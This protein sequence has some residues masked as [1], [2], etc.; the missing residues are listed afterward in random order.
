MLPVIALVGRPNVG[1]STFFNLLTKSRDALVADLPG[2]T[3]DRLYG[4]GEFEGKK[5]IVIDTG[6]LTGNEAGIDGLMAQQTLTAIEEADSIF[7]I[8]DGRSGLTNNDEVLA[9]QLRQFHKPIHLVVNKTDGVNPDI[10]T[11]EFNSLGLGLPYGISATH[12]QGVR[13]LLTNLIAI[14]ELPAENLDETSTSIKTA[15]IG[16]PNAGKSTLINRMLGEERQL[17]FDAPGTTRDSVYIPFTRHEKHYTLIDTA[18]VRRR[19]KIS[20]TVEKFSV[21]KTLQAITAANVVILVI[22]AKIGITDQD[23][24]L[25]GFVLDE[26]KSL[27]IA[28]NKWDG[29][30]IDIKDQIR[31]DL[32]RRL[33]FVDFALQ[34]FISALHGTGVGDLFKSIDKV[35][36]SATKK[37]STPL[38]TRALEKAVAVHQPPLVHGRRVKLRYAHAGGHNPPI[39]VIHGNQTKHLPNTYQRYLINFFRKALKLVGTPIRLELKDSTN[40]YAGKKNVLTPRQLQKRKRLMN[41]VRKR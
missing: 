16:K 38:L 25:L 27:I 20:D 10:V 1:K 13:L 30:E 5:F 31:S 33:T 12:N 37:L 4:K 3:R 36:A 17:V 11:A 18:G 41:F 21:V 32:D 6:G 26:G 22:D 24:D 29:L 35:Y 23:L 40:P 28:I 15:I 34:H 19:S 39:I 2:L 7:F 8:V 9:R 14:N